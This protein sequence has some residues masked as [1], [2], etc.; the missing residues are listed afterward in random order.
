M[1]AKRGRRSVGTCLAL[2]A[3]GKMSAGEA[4]FRLAL[5]AVAPALASGCVREYHFHPSRGWRLDFAWPAAKLAA[6]VDGGQYA[7]RGGRHA[8]DADREKLNHAAALGWRV[9]RFSPQQIA[10]DPAACVA[11][12]E[13]ALDAT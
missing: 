2:D 9:L 3:P 7:P 13:T 10:A 11:L 1:K 5:R 6:E 8:T 4:A 12:V